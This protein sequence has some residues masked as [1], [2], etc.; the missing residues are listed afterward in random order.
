MEAVTD[1]N[2]RYTIVVPHGPGHV[3]VQGPSADYSHLSTSASEMGIGLRPSFRLYPDAHQELDLK[4]GVAS[5]P[6][7]LGLR[8]G[9]TI[10]GRVIAPDGKPVAEAY[11]FGRSYTPY[12]EHNFPLVGFNGKPPLIAV[13]DGRFE[14]P[15]CDPDNPDA[16]Y[17]LD[18]K[19]RLGTTVVL[20]GKSAAIGPV[21]VRLERTATARFLLKDQTGRPVANHVYADWPELKLIITRGPDFGELSTNI[22]LTPGDFAY[23]YD[24]DPVPNRGIR[25]GPDGYVRMIN[26]IPG[27]AYRFRGGIFTPEPGQTIALDDVM[28]E[29][30]SK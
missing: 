5:Y 18:L 4:D 3:L 2:G 22:D 10:A 23:Q 11:I 24:L 21:T 6:L 1:R 20:S 27:A 17:F 29:P 28:V 8:R 12:R 15:G 26:L 19:D 7:D 30:P 9:V 13:K 16:F 14:I 25:S